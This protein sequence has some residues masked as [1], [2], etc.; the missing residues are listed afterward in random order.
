MASLVMHCSHCQ[1]TVSDGW[2][3]ATPNI[4]KS[5]RKITAWSTGCIAQFFLQWCTRK[6]LVLS[7]GWTL[8]PLQSRRPSPC[9]TIR[10][11][12]HPLKLS[13]KL[14]VSWPTMVSSILSMKQNY[15]RYWQPL[16]SCSQCSLGFLDFS[17]TA[18]NNYQA[19]VKCI[20]WQAKLLIH[21]LTDDTNMCAAIKHQEP[22][23]MISRLRQDCPSRMQG[24]LLGWTK[25]TIGGAADACSCL[26]S[27]GLCIMIHEVS[28]G[29]ICRSCFIGVDTWHSVKTIDQ[30]YLVRGHRQKWWDFVNRAD[31]VGFKTFIHSPEEVRLLHFP[32]VNANCSTF[33]T[34]S[35]VW[36]W[37]LSSSV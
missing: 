35:W 20:F 2:F 34:H 13:K 9:Q 28:H 29:I 5:L 26:T 19:Q 12:L 11:W 31:S 16:I 33:P 8:Q 14:H 6:S 36:C 17:V 7:E 1:G 15:C 22:R 21:M 27:V 32:M 10:I 3:W 30:L 25:L 4:A 24:P 23:T 37:I 18:W